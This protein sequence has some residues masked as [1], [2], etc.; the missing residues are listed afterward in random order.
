MTRAAMVV[1]VAL[2]SAPAAAQ[3]RDVTFGVRG[4]VSDDADFG[5]GADVRWRFLRD[6]PRLALTLGV[7]YF[8]PEQPDT[9]LEDLPFRDLFPELFPQLPFDLDTDVRYWEANLNLTWDFTERG[10]VVPYAGVGLNYARAESTVL[11]QDFEDDEFGANVLAG[12]RIGRH[13]YVEA[14]QEAGGG[15]MFVASVGVRF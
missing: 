9:G 1:A 10:T 15:E 7:D 11:G 8:F 5:V 12:V 3:D 2:L 6:D 13:V 14:K 4:S